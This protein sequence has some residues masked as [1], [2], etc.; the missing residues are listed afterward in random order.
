MEGIDIYES[1]RGVCKLYIGKCCEGRKFYSMRAR[2]RGIGF[3]SKK[4]FL[5]LRMSRSYLSEV[6]G[7]D[8]FIRRG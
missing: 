7:I 5:N 3:N 4:C 6:W 1:F 8:I 2:Y